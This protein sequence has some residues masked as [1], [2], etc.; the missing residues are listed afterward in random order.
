M[1]N[2]SKSFKLDGESIKNRILEIMDKVGVAPKRDHAVA[3]L[4][5]GIWTDDQLSEA[6]ILF[7]SKRIDAAVRT[8]KNERGVHLWASVDGLMKQT[9]LFN[10]EDYESVINDRNTALFA[11]YSVL[12]AYQSECREKFSA[13]PAIPDLSEWTSSRGI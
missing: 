13:A 11:D 6:N 12:V 9:E 4:G 5:E 1:G 2:D 3:C 10:Y 7:A 8:S